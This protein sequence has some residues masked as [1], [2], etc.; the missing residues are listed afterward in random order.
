MAW[1]FVR[2][3]GYT[4]SEAL[5]CAWANIKLRSAMLLGIVEFY[6]KKVD[7]SIRQAFGT[8]KADK[9]PQTTGESKRKT[10]SNV[11]TYFDTEKN[12]WRCFKRCNILS[13]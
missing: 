1:T 7:G 2:Q 12:E 4:L 9:L 10:S 8:L 5:K 13:L 11:F 3:N 6:Y